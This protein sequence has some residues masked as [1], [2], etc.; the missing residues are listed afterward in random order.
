[1]ATPVGSRDGSRD[2][3]RDGTGTSESRTPGGARIVAT[4]Q[5][6]DHPDE[7]RRF[8]LESPERWLAPRIGRTPNGARNLMYSPL[9]HGLTLPELAGLCI[10][11]FSATQ[12]TER[13]ARWDAPIR[14][15]Q[16]GATPRPLS[17]ELF[18]EVA[19]VDAEKDLAEARYLAQPSRE[20]ASPL[21]RAI[22]RCVARLTVLRASILAKHEITDTE[23][24]R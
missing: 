14:T 19:I 7:F 12:A 10:E 22:D 11:A 24:G 17:P 23:D 15:A 18:Y 16:A 9:R 1:M 3:A 8:P 6:P 21:I 4:I 20:H 13:L 2:G 5:P